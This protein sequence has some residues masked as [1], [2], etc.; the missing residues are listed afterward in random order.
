M[1]RAH[2]RDGSFYV[3]DPSHALE[4][5]TVVSVGGRETVVERRAGT[6]RR[7]LVRLRGVESADGLRGE[8]L[9]VA[10]AEAPLE[11]GEWLVE[12]LVG[13]RVEG[14]GTVNRVL[15]APSCPLLELDDGTLVPFVSPA[16]ES[17][18]T[19]ARTIRARLDFLGE[20]T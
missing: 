17:V 20:S 8:P 7:P 2:G 4:P 11:E 6:D 16:I 1:G 15:D 10:L 12:D 14:L 19:R 13:C 5:G 3:E 9:L 18:D